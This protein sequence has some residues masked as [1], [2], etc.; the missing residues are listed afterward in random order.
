MTTCS[1]ELSLGTQAKAL[2]VFPPL[3]L[4]ILIGAFLLGNSYEELSAAETQAYQVQGLAKLESFYPKPSSRNKSVPQG[5]LVERRSE[6]ITPFSLI[7]ECPGERWFCRIT[8]SSNAFTEAGFDG[9]NVYD[10]LK[11]PIKGGESLSR[12]VARL[13]CSS[14]GLPE[15]CHP[16]VRF[17]WLGLASGQAIRQMKPPQMPPPWAAGKAIMPE[18]DCFT[19]KA[20]L[21]DDLLGCPESVKFLF[22]TDLW[23]RDNRKLSPP[24]NAGDE[25]GSYQVFSVT[26]LDSVKIPVAFEMTRAAEHLE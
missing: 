25:V 4:S 5:L 17:L 3:A 18:S 21:H 8:W 1:P 12:G 11:S 26:N 7:A 22:S 24:F 20:R 2:P 13:F 19:F 6:L 16:L 15:D 9:T 14:N 23:K 10:L